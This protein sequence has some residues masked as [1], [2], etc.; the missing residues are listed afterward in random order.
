MGNEKYVP[1]AYEEDFEPTLAEVLRRL[2]DAIN[3]SFDRLALAIQEN[4]EAI[5]AL[6]ETAERCVNGLKDKNK[7]DQNNND[8]KDIPAMKP[9]RTIA[10]RSRRKLRWWCHLQLVHPDDSSD[11]PH[12]SQ[13]SALTN[14]RFIEHFLQ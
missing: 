13:D 5:E 12:R 6:R 9:V 8:Q 2:T 7:C 3:D 4:T 11:W 1:G 14:S 10:R